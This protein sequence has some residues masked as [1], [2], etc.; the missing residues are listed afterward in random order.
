MKILLG[1]TSQY[2]SQIMSDMHKTVSVCQDWSPELNNNVCGHAHARM[3]AQCMETCMQT[4]IL[5][6]NEIRFL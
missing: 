4:I 6:L 1:N 5:Q 2:R 3:H